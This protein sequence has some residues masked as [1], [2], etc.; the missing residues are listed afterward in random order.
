MA[1]RPQGDSVAYIVKKIEFDP[2][3]GL[4]GRCLRVKKGSV[5]ELLRQK[6][7]LVI[8]LGVWGD[9]SSV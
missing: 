8:G 7:Y 3:K 2:V 6:C 1:L 5:N 4:L 9:C